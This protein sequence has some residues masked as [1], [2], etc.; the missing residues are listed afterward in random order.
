MAKLYTGAF[1]EFRHEAIQ[2]LSI[3]DR[4]KFITANIDRCRN[5]LNELT[6]SNDFVTILK[7]IGENFLKECIIFQTLVDKIPITSVEPNLIIITRFQ[8]HLLNPIAFFEGLND[9]GFLQSIKQEF[10]DFHEDYGYTISEKH[11]IAYDH[12]TPIKNEDLTEYE[13]QSLENLRRFDAVLQNK[14]DDQ[15]QYTKDL[16][17]SY[18]NERPDELTNYLK[19][20]KS[21]LKFLI[22]NSKACKNYP[23]VKSKLEKLH[24]SL[25]PKSIAHLLSTSPKYVTD[26]SL[27]FSLPTND[28]VTA[29]NISRIVFD[30]LNKEIGCTKPEVNQMLGITD[31]VRK[32]VWP[33]K[34]WRLNY[35]VNSLTKILPALNGLKDIKFKIAGNC[36]VN[37]SHQPITPK[38]IRQAKI[39]Q[40]ATIKAFD[41]MHNDILSVLHK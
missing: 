19:P 7:G 1:D 20:I 10:Y 21:K 18:N 2:K 9:N 16:I 4:V 29:E 31:H 24:S 25:L 40:D 34:K 27:H 22:N 23:S 14:V 28:N 6:S 13:I 37:A 32:I 8:S 33:L 26:P 39:P 12:P 36:F 5:S 41:D 38:S 15:I 11:E 17:A 35:F 3:D 30:V